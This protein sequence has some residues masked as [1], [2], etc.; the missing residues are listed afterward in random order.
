MLNRYNGK[1]IVYVYFV[2]SQLKVIESWITKFR[3]PDLLY[4]IL[5]PKGQKFR[6]RIS[7]VPHCINIFQMTDPNACNHMRTAVQLLNSQRSLFCT[8]MVGEERTCYSHL[9]NDSVS[10]IGV[11]VMDNL[12]VM[13]VL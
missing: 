8:I 7:N 4:L 11:A 6:S 2:H 1:A 5:D 9:C 12:H 13:S 10:Q 3:H